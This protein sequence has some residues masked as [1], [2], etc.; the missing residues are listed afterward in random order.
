MDIKRPSQSIMVISEDLGWTSY[1]WAATFIKKEPFASEQVRMLLETVGRHNHLTPIY[2]PDVLPE[3]ELLEIER[4]SAARDPAS[5]VARARFRDLLRSDAGPSRRALF[6]AYHYRIDPVFDDRP[7][8]FEYFKPGKPGELEQAGVGGLVSIRGP[9]GYYV[10][11]ALLLICVAA[12][13]ACIVLPLWVFQRR[14]LETPGA[15]PL[16]LYFAC[17]GSG[18]MLFEIGAMQ[19]VNVYL[20]DPAISLAVVLAGLLVATGIG[21]FWAS[22]YPAHRA[23]PVITIGALTIGGAICVWLAFARY[24]QPLTMHRGM[25]VRVAVVLAGL[26]PI[27]ALLGLPF[28]TAIRAIEQQYPGFIAWAWGVNGVA[29]V[30]ASIVAI[31]VAMR[32]GFSAVVLIAAAVY[33]AAVVS[34]RV[35]DVRR[36]N[37]SQFVR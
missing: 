32:F 16:V 22:R 19:L 36:R 37:S 23:L 1:R 8:F 7:F 10:L 28:P 4:A 14:G 21:S 2:V 17:L 33:L 11:Y 6:A 18:F 26:L 31:L 30:L 29:S 9:I 3:T 12:C 25:P 34:F 24:V 27:G 15:V 13:G 20:G 5:T 35:F